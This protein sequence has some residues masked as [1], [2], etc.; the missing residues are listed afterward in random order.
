MQYFD[1]GRRYQIRF[2]KQGSK[3]PQLVVGFTVPRQTVIESRGRASQPV[4]R[5]LGSCRLRQWELPS[6]KVVV[7]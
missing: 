3:S 4:A 7:C 2:R 5:D 1:E 6:G